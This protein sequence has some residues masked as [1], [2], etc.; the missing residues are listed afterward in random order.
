M[1]DKLKCTVLFFVCLLCIFLL[2]KASKRHNGDR[3]GSYKIAEGGARSSREL[4]DRRGRGRLA[5][6]GIGS[7][8]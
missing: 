8:S 6:G 7:S 4:G 1:I 2:T 3:R 5:V